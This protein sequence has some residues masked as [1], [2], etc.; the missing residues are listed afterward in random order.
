M[1]T[2]KKTIMYKKEIEYDLETGDFAMYLDGELVGFARTYVEAEE[3]L[4]QL[5]YELINRI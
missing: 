5:I 4:D 1:Q 3:T 2:N